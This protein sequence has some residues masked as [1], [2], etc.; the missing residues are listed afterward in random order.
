MKYSKNSSG[1]D[2]RQKVIG[3]SDCS[4]DAL[5]TKI[6]NSKNTEEIY[7]I[8]GNK[9]YIT[10][11]MSVTDIPEDLK[12]GDALLFERG[13]VFR[14][15]WHQG[16]DLPNGVII[17]SYG[18]GDKPRFYGSQRNFADNSLW[19][20]VE[21]K[22]NIIR[23]FLH[24]GN[25]GNIVFDDVACLGVKKWSLDDVKENYD[26]FY[27]CDEYLYLYYE[28]NIGED[29]KSIEISQRE[30]L[31]TYGSDCIVDN[32]CLKYTG[33]HAVAAKHGTDNTRVTNCEIGFI[34]GSMQFGKTRFGNGIELPIGATR[35]TVKNNYVYQCYD[36]GITFQSWSSCGKESHYHDIDFSENLIENCCYGIE[37]FTTNT[38]GS[39][40]YSDYKN[41]SFKDNII[42]FSGYEWSQLQ[43]P[44]PWMTSHIR[45]GQWAYMDDCENFTITDNVF[46]ISRACIV[47]WWWHDESKN[48]IHPEPHKGLTVK[49]NTY[50]QAPTP[51]KRCMTFHENIP[52]C[53]ENE[54]EFLQAVKLFDKE[55]AK[56][57]WLEQPDITKG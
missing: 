14:I 49:N 12:P 32:L 15:L 11:E 7:E 46:D 16:I 6:L 22:D 8:K 48:V 57:V 28:G 31:I 21:G 18:V 39:G 20:K 33:A 45:G 29:F 30:I 3:N 43:R 47:F 9:Y 50:Y 56:A 52:V 41:I 54:A 23:T 44:D 17:G 38:E 26:F 55:P 24:G 35:A 53:A 19:E 13:G 25:A 42:R 37:Y 4:A 27:D 2:Y 40:L 10:K 1:Y 36:A 51:D 34:G 5:R